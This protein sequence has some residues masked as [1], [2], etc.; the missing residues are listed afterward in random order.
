MNIA[1]HASRTATAAG[2]TFA[3]CA[4]SAAS[5]TLDDSI[6]KSRH[7]LTGG[8]AYQT[9][10]FTIA[11][12]V[13]GNPGVSLKLD[14][15]EIDDRDSS[16]YLEY[17]YRLGERWSIIAGTYQFSGSGSKQTERTIDYD[18]VEFTAGTTIQSQLEVDAYVVDLVYQVFAR[19]NFEIMLGGGV[20]A[21]DL[22]A[23]IAG[24][25]SIDDTSSEFRRA[26]ATVLAPVPNL[27]L[28]ALWALTDRWALR[29]NSGWLSANIDE[30]EGGFLYGHLRASYEITDRW[31]LSLGYQYTDVDV[32]QNRRAGEISFD[33]Q[34]AGP[35]LTTSYAF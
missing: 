16:Y 13:D 11:A 25:V 1:V 4:V 17:K 35:T 7:V 20:H 27:R 9:T 31:G 23:S 19:D 14:D 24:Q 29:L 34:L 30:Y 33:V 6:Y 28:T 3:L 8:L 18:G 21:L 10:D 2:V 26:S 22:G 32:T 5:Q 12:G 15:L